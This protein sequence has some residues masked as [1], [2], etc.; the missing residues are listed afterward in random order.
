MTEAGW[1]GVEEK[2]ENKMESDAE[3]ADQAV[4]GAKI[5]RGGSASFVLNRA[6]MC[7]MM[8]AHI[9]TRCTSTTRT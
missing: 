2:R 9:R 3:H 8:I 4:M 5:V 1:L 7:M 6:R